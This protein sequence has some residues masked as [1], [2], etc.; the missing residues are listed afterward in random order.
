MT[1][2]A[3]LA[4]VGITLVLVWSRLARAIAFGVLGAVGL[5]TIVT[6]LVEPASVTLGVGAL[7][8]GIA[9]TGLAFMRRPRPPAPAPLPKARV[10]DRRQEP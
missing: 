2:L 3:L 9:V 6:G 4:L 1:P 5:A 10:I 7:W 8:L